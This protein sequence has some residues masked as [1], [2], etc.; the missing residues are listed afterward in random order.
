MW[1]K[2]AI[3]LIDYADV[4]IDS[5]PK[6]AKVREKII[7]AGRVRLTPVLLTAASTIF[8]LLPLAIGMNIDFASLFEHLDPNIFFGGMSAVFWGPLAWTIIFGLAFATFLTLVVVPAM[9]FMWYVAKIRKERRKVHKM[10][11]RTA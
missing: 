4:S 10:I 5:K 2:N 7:E 3:I 9:Y 11:A 1:L 8:G 6:E